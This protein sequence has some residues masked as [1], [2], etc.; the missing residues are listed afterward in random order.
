ML[1]AEMISS[2]GAAIVLGRLQQTTDFHQTTDRILFDFE[3]I[4]GQK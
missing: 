1:H 2:F 3:V 4:L